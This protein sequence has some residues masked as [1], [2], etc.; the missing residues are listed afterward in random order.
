MGSSSN[1]RVSRNI[2]SRKAIGIIKNHIKLKREDDL[3]RKQLNAMG[4]PMADNKP[5]TSKQSRGLMSGKVNRTKSKKKLQTRAESNLKDDLYP[6]VKVNSGIHNIEKEIE[7][8]IIADKISQSVL[9]QCTPSSSNPNPNL[10]T[11]PDPGT[12]MERTMS[13]RRQSKGNT[14]SGV[15]SV[16]H[17]LKMATMN[18]KP[19]TRS[20]LLGV[21]SQVVRA[22]PIGV[23]LLQACLRAPLCSIAGRRN[24]AESVARWRNASR[25]LGKAIRL[26]DKDCTS[27]VLFKMSDYLLDTTLVERSDFERLANLCHD[28]FG[29][30]FLPN[31]RFDETYVTTNYKSPAVD[32]VSY[33]D[34]RDKVLLPVWRQLKETTMSFV[35]G[36]G[37]P[38]IS[39][40]GGGRG[41]SALFQ[42]CVDNVI[43]RGKEAADTAT[44]I[45]K[46]VAAATVAGQIVS[47]PYAYLPATIRKS[48]HQQQQQQQKPQHQQQQQQQQHQQQLLHQQP[49]QNSTAMTD[50]KIFSDGSY[51]KKSSP[52][53]PAISAMPPSPKSLSSVPS[54]RLQPS[55]VLPS[56]PPSS[57]GIDVQSQQ[58]QTH[59][60]MS[61]PIPH[62]TSTFEDVNNIELEWY[63]DV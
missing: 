41:N 60:S 3:R 59:Q 52:Q 36:P 24:T 53:P 9:V 1:K 14:K 15:S 31:K 32:G 55:R 8:S 51:A 25:Q 43:A 12:V 35:V 10:I 30:T 49:S 7:S 54:W 50:Y 38:L 37:A 45:K 46:G 22:S 40:N 18:L 27:E 61:H 13:G 20:S 17:N 47:L 44:D 2:T 19:P 63:D 33:R 48:M 62:E 16:L 23:M 56:T 6:K 57:N 4:M 42:A 11:L 29:V 34:Y 26:Q 28:L 39:L 21:K 58:E 5:L